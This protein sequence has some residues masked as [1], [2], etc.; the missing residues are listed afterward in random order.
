MAAISLFNLEGFK[1]RK[2]PSTNSAGS[3]KAGIR[4]KTGARS[5][6]TRKLR[7]AFVLPNWWGQFT[8]I[9]SFISSEIDGWARNLPEFTLASR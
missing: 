7:E 4:C 9:L 2:F 1:Q 5:S 3:F 8:L 6:V